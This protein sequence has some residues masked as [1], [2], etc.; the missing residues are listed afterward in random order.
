M[1]WV[2]WAIHHRWVLHCT[3]PSWSQLDP[4]YTL[5]WPLQRGKANTI[6]FTNKGGINRERIGE[7]VQRRRMKRQ[8]WQEPMYRKSINKGAALQQTVYT[9][10]PPSCCQ[11]PVRFSRRISIRI[12]SYKFSTGTLFFTQAQITVFTSNRKKLNKRRAKGFFPYHFLSWI[13]YWAG[14]SATSNRR[15][16]QAHWSTGSTLYVQ[17]NGKYCNVNLIQLHISDLALK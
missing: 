3:D 15:C 4:K 17:R 7:P 5:S 11:D 10:P 14:V 1:S 2:W 8:D 6:T 16:L 9:T 13:T 12:W